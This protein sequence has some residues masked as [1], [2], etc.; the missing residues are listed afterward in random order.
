MRK[1]LPIL[2]QFAETTI[3]EMSLLSVEEQNKL[4]PIIK[5][6]PE[7]KKH[8]LEEEINT[9]GIMISG[10]IFDD[11]S[12]YIAKNNIKNIYN[13]YKS[14]ATVKIGIFVTKVKEILTKSNSKMIIINGFDQTQDI[15]AILFNNQY[16]EF[17]HLVKEEAYLALTGYFRNDENYGLSF[18]INKVEIME[19]NK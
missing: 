15:E 6:I 12:S 3:N 10:S 4:K 14:K 1:A 19:A 2:I 13:V 7:D 9:L 5:N 17:A 16:D 11:Y 18:V 8:N